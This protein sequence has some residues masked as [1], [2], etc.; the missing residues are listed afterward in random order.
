MEHLIRK[1]LIDIQLNS[2]MDSFS[3]QQKLSEQ[4]WRFLIPLMEEVFDQLQ[5][6]DEAILIDSL[7]INLGTIELK[8]L[9]RINQNENLILNIKNQ[10]QSQVNN[11]EFLNKNIT[12]KSISIKDFDQWIFYVKNGFFDWNVNTLN[13]DWYNHVLEALATDTDLLEVFIE[14]IKTNPNSLL[15]LIR[16]HEIQFLSKLT[17]ILAPDFIEEIS[18]I[19]KEYNYNNQLF[20]LNS[21]EFNR[22]FEIFWKEMFQTCIVIR[23]E[24]I[25]KESYNPFDHISFDVQESSSN[26]I[27]EPEYSTADFKE[28]PF[29]DS[30]FVDYVGIILLHPFLHSLFKKLDLIHDQTFINLISREKAI[31]VLYYLLTGKLNP[32]EFELVVPKIICGYPIK[33]AISTDIMLSV[34]DRAEADTML[35]AVIANWDILKNTSIDGLR[36]GFLIR[37]GKIDWVDDKIKILVEKGPIDMLLDYLPWSLNIIK[38]PWLK[39]LI[40]VDWR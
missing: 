20:K 2:G 18:S 24:N 16:Q 23:H 14:E 34:A 3:I 13:T 8:D 12:R 28:T 30:L 36:E 22:G 39:Q 37:R 38:L 5:P 17:K 25:R 7:S 19:E 21:I 11:D 6:I 32:K 29:T 33:A 40:Q 27:I 35:E 9:D 15:R 1:Q 10:I 26:E 31:Y 4:Y